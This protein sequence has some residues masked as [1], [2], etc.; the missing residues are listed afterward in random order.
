MSLQK[1]N[2]EKYTVCGRMILG[3]IFCLGFA[4]SST[5]KS[6]RKTNQ[7]A[8]SSPQNQAVYKIYDKTVTLKDVTES[9]KATFYELN[10][11]I[12]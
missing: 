2:I 6:L 5:A 10:K 9:D 7:G 3:F 12:F 1:A 11:R 8:T 4:G